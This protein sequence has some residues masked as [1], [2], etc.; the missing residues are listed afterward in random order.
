MLDTDF[1]KFSSLKVFDH[2]K[3]NLPDDAREIAEV[4][5]DLLFVWN[6]K[7]SNIRVVNWRAAQT[8]SNKGKEIKHQV[9]PFNSS[10]CV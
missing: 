4:Y 9:G 5:E 7:N 1:L 8:S 6:F 2:V 3:E 10:K